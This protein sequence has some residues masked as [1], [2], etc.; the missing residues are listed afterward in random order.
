MMGRWHPAQSTVIMVT[1][2]VCERVS[3]FL[4]VLAIDTGKVLVGWMPD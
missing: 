3:L 4:L 2:G 1:M